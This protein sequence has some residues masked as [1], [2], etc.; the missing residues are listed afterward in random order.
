MVS[1]DSWKKLFETESLMLSF[2]H[3]LESNY[4]F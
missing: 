1:L 2:E 4:L 3:I